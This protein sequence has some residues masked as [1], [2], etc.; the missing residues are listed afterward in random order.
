MNKNKIVFGFL[1][2]SVTLST[3]LTLV[4]GLPLPARA[5]FCDTIVGSAICIDPPEESGSDVQTGGNSSR[6]ILNL[7]NS[8]S[9]PIYTAYVKYSSSKGWSSQG[10]YKVEVNRCRPIDL[11]SYRGDVY[12]Y[13]QR[14]QQISWGR[15][16]AFFCINKTNAFDLPNS[17]MISCNGSELKRVGMSK[18][19]VTAGQ[20]THSFK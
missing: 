6:A 1:S 5:D 8:T 19:T 18:Q 15:N 13:A 14:G 20:N 16:D 11:G 17:D 4:F 12:V 9:A 7:C 10:F 3:L 2:G